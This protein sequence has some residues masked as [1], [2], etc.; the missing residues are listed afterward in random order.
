[1]NMSFGLPVF[2]ALH[3]KKTMLT[4]EET[5]S[6]LGCGCFLRPFHA[7]QRLVLGAGCCRAFCFRGEMRWDGVQDR[8]RK[9]AKRE[10]GTPLGSVGFEK[11]RQFMN[12]RWVM[13]VAAALCCL[14]V[15]GCAGRSDDAQWGAVCDVYLENLPA[16]YG[17]LPPAIR[18]NTRIMLF[19][20]SAYLDKRYSIELTEAN[21]YHQRV[22][23]LPGS[24]SISEVFVSN[25]ALIPLSATAQEREI[26]LE[27][28]QETRLAVSLEEPSLLAQS[29]QL[30]RPTQEIIEAEPFSRQ[31][32]YDGTILDLR[33]IRETIRLDAS[34][35]GQEKLGVGETCELSTPDHSGVRL[36]VKNTTGA[37]I[38][39][40][41]ASV[42]GIRFTKN[43]AVFPGGITV[44]APLKSIVNA[45]TGRLG[46]PTYCTGSPLIGFNRCTL[47]YLDQNSGDR[48]SIEIGGARPAVTSIFYEFEV[49]Q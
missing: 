21:G 44:G 14:M 46:T 29:I 27:K 30:S 37:M 39:A 43:N 17:E 8:M 5:T 18:E 45:K 25:H 16:A 11:R 10:T 48:L 2:V 40:S 47:V 1:M 38:A 34:E 42:I 28:D 41:E 7:L 6:G 9:N 35:E 12:Q 3:Y 23:M 20:A 36:T 22:F 4:V 24:Y 19:A 31:I 32:Q 49:Y 26:I 33:C 13:W 15:S